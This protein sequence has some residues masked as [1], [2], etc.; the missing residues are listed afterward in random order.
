MTTKERLIHTEISILPLV[1]ED[2][3]YLEPILRQHVRDRNTGVIVEEEL[4]A[5]KEYMLG[6]LDE[7]GRKRSY[8]V[9]KTAEG[10]VLGC[11]AYAV[12]DPDM[13]A[14]FQ[15]DPGNSV[16]LLNAFVDQEVYRGSG[17]GRKLFEAVCQEAKSS[18]MTQ[19]LIHSGP[20]YKASWGFYDKMCG[21]NQ[22]MLIEKYGQGGDAMTWKKAL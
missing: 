12:P 20:R 14:H 8:L 9:A 18:G 11:M 13:L 3:P 17:V 4:Q 15:A 21:E 6:A 10:E 2:I 16:E 1:E 5:I 7:C 22:G 19:L